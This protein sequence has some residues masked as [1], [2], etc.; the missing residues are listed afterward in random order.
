MSSKKPHFHYLGKLKWTVPVEHVYELT[1]KS[2]TLQLRAKAI[3]SDLGRASALDH[4]IWDEII[5]KQA[6]PHKGWC[7]CLTLWTRDLE[8]NLLVFGEDRAPPQIVRCAYFAT[9][10]P[11]MCREHLR[12]WA[13]IG[14]CISV[15]EL[16]A[17]VEREKNR[18]GVA[19]MGTE[20][21]EA[22]KDAR[23]AHELLPRL[24]LWN[25]YNYEHKDP[26]TKIV[27]L[28]FKRTHTLALDHFR[29]ELQTIPVPTDFLEDKDKPLHFV[30][31]TITA[32]GQFYELILDRY[33]AVAGCGSA[34][35]RNLLTLA[36][37][38]VD[39]NIK[40]A[41]VTGEPGTGKENL[42]KAIY[43]GNKL[44]R[45]RE[46]EPES[47]FVQTT[48]VEIQSAMR[49][50]KGKKT[51][52]EF[53]RDELPG[54]KKSS[55][56]WPPFSKATTVKR[57][58]IYIDELNKAEQDFL[59]AMLRLLEQGKTELQ[60]KDDPKY[61]L[62]ASQHIDD[63]ARKPP[64]DFWTRI[65]HQ[66]RVVHPLSRVSEEDGKAFLESFFYSQWWSVIEEMI[67]GYDLKHAKDFVKVFLGKMSIKGLKPSG[68]CNRVKDEFLNTLVPLVSRDTLSVRGARSI[69]SQVFA[70][71]SWFVRF[72]D[73][74]ENPRRLD[75]LT[76]NEVADLVN[77]AVQDVMA[78]L[79]AARATSAGM[80]EKKPNK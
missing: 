10:E 75:P 23:S 44:N 69:L 16:Q 52:S 28:T 1:A 37:L 22:E 24:V 54:G 46:D 31:D 27:K 63:L 64:Q 9:P 14:V 58:V 20:E 61:I 53:L 40:V 6:N 76:Q 60:I 35:K 42:C 49:R 5:K 25:R 68:F 56:F 7:D 73:P 38:L 32:A 19:L 30:S 13:T 2:E 21:F 34:M 45:P 80:E 55:S 66:L 17:A 36:S 26:N 47:V 12:Y 59:G 78:I 51:P 15:T 33:A 11:K 4:L 18:P 79:N 3:T 48:A 71:L 65:S 74:L 39:T 77:S 50:K 62:A 29:S 57:P 8:F 72:E 43:Y 41:L 67:R 70:R